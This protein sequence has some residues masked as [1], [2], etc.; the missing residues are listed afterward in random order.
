MMNLGTIEL[1]RG[2][3]FSKTFYLGTFKKITSSSSA[4]PSV[5]T[6]PA[7][8]FSS[9]QKKQIT[10]HKANTAI[11]NDVDNPL[12]TI[13][14]IDANTFSVPI[15]GI[16]SGYGGEVMT[17]DNLTGLVAGTDIKCQWRKYRMGTLTAESAN[18]LF[19]PT[20]AIETAA[21]GS[22]TISVAKALTLSDNASGLTL[23]RYGAD[24]LVIS[25]GEYSILAQF[26]VLCVKTST[27]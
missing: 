24:I 20:I 1:V 17:P 5:V 19:T 2:E 7:H 25:G 27:R 23:D 21:E 12:H 10:N 18:V 8:G 4:N 14:V 9:S 26:D 3:D 22:I 11:N 15:A 16:A 13:T 6:V